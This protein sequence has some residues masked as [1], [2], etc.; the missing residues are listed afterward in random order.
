MFFLFHFPRYK[1][2][3]EIRNRLLNMRNRL[4]PKALPL[5]QGLLFPSDLIVHFSYHKCLTSYYIA[6]IRQLAAEFGFFS[7][8]F[9]MEYDRFE[10][11]AVN[12]REKRL[13]SLN[14]R[15][16]DWEKLQEY[17]GS[18]FIRDPRDLVVSGYYYNQWTTEKWCNDPNFDWADI[19]GH[20]LFDKYVESDKTRYPKN[21]SYKKYLR[22][23][24]REQG[25]ILEIMRREDSFS[26]MR[27]WNFENH[28]IIEFK[29]EDIIGN[30]GECCRRIFKHYGFH[31]ELIRRGVKIAE[32]YSLK[33]QKAKDSRFHVR[34]GMPGQWAREFSPFIK[35]LFMQFH[36]DL[37]R[38][39]GYEG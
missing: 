37:L 25:F 6:I 39:L 30:E 4:Y 1:V 19:T 36:G 31:P 5:E 15:R 8:H 16:V 29:Y 10:D 14:N 17:K 24:N 27:E 35:K 20:P 3:S 32:K 11:A 26:Q 13:V 33:N 18:H 23:L 22:H 28:R 34:N 2:I 7:K 38:T 21:I 9:N 12:K